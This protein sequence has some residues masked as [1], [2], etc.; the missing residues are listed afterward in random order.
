MLSLLF[1][2]FFLQVFWSKFETLFKFFSQKTNKFWTKISSL[3]LSPVSFSS[4]SLP[5]L[6]HPNLPIVFFSRFL[7]LFLV[8]A[9]RLNFLGICFRSTFTFFK[10][11]DFSSCFWLAPFN[12]GSKMISKT[13]RHYCKFFAVAQVIGYILVLAPLSLP[14]DLLSNIPLLAIPLIIRMSFSLF[15]DML[16][17]RKGEK[18]INLQVV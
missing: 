4:C 6:V 18:Q 11:L 5:F 8:F 2:A 1:I 15:H 13:W 9:I 7:S 16:D 12:E 10:S 14:L 3:L 17:R